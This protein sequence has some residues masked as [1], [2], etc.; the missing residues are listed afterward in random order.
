MF[1][2]RKYLLSLAVLFVL[3]G[4]SP[5]SKYESYVLALNQT[6]SSFLLDKDS[7]DFLFSNALHP[8]T[9]TVYTVEG[10][11]FVANNLPVM[12]VTLRPHE[13]VYWYADIKQE[14]GTVRRAVFNVEMRRALGKWDGV[15]R[16][17]TSGKHKRLLETV[18]YFQAKPEQESTVLNLGEFRGSPF[19]TINLK[20]HVNVMTLTL[21]SPPGERLVFEQGGKTTYATKWT[22]DLETLKAPTYTF[23]TENAQGF[24]TSRPIEMIYEKVYTA[25]R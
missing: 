14:D 7:Q 24:R 23:T 13:K 1:L 5:T 2:L 12:E 4:C 9:F 8:V 21:E 22:V 11:T 19:A 18:H 16:V 3:A 20:G 10:E 25:E 17:Y 6:K 15:Q